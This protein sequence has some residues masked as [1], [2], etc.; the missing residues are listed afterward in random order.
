MIV[1]YLSTTDI[2][3]FHP[4]LHSYL[5]LKQIQHL[6]VLERPNFK[7]ACVLYSNAS[8]TVAFYVV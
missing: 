6:I 8:L 5:I 4:F 2:G 7:V 1:F 3:K